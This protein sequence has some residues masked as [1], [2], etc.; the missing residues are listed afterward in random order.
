[1]AKN[2][3][4]KHAPVAKNAQLNNKERMVTTQR[5]SYR[6]IRDTKREPVYLRSLAYKTAI[7]NIRK[8]QQ[9]NPATRVLNVKW[10]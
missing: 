2:Q 6:R 5:S 4:E 9:M 1:L 8:Q 3:I 7:E 10:I